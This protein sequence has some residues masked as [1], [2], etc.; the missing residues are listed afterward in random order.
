MPSD[1]VSQPNLVVRDA[2]ERAISEL[3][4]AF[5]H[6]VIDVEDFERRLAMVHRAASVS[7]IAQASS[8]L[9]APIPSAVAA[10]VP[11]KSPVVGS[12]PERQSLLA[13]L[14][15][16]ERRSVWTPPRR[17]DV[18]ALMGGV[19]LDFRDASLAPGVTEV[20]VIALMGGVQIIVPPSLAV[21]VTG[22]AVL[23]GFGHVERAPRR[24]DPD[25]PVLRVFGV[26]LMGGVSV[27]TR[28]EG[29]SERDARS[30]RHHE[31]GALEPGPNP[32]RLPE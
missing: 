21:E 26:A 27:E 3:S 4:D 17:L 14:G 29:E 28:L 5:A 11:T 16:V 20:R 30:R 8:G 13:V 12:V 9:K 1:P 7:D 18:L 31:V 10:P 15:G 2:R 32:K 22:T 6:D 25:R 24:P 23:G 19:V